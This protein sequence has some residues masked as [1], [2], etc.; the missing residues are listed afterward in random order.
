MHGLIDNP[1]ASDYTTIAV[2][3]TEEG[4]ALV[5]SSALS[6]DKRVRENL[7]STEKEAKGTKG[8]H[9]EE[10]VI[11]LAK[12]EKLS[13]TEI[14]ASRPICLDCEELLEE[15]NILTKTKFSGKKS[16]KRQ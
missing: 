4:L 14:G 3:N 9:A 1:I 7:V 8:Q 15:N 11:Q 10:K 6:L 12:E 16:K 2:L 13:P 5:G